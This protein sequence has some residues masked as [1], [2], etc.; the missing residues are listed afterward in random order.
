[1]LTAKQ[2]AALCQLAR[3]AWE[4]QGKPGTLETFRQEH[5]ETACGAA[6]LRGACNDDYLP[7]KRRF[8]MLAKLDVQEF[9]TALRETGETKRRNI[10]NL[11]AALALAD[12][13]AAYAE[14]IARDKFGHGIE[15]CTDRELVQLVI[16]IRSR[17]YAAKRKGAAAAQ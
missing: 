11:G 4:V 13:P 5:V 8:E 6:G 10:H 3:K 16:T 2:K 1:M 12:K 14:A 17:A 7:I 15:H 9:E